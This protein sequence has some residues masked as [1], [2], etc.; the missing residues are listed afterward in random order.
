LRLLAVAKRN[1]QKASDNR[2][3][4]EKDLTF[5]GFV[6]IADPPRKEIKDVLSVTRKAGIATIMVTGDNPVTARAIASQIGLIQDGE[7]VV[8]GTELGKMSDDELL[9]KIDAIRIFARTTP[10]DKLRIVRI[11]QK[12]GEI[13]T[14]TG[15]GV[16]DALA[17]KQAHTGVAMGITG[18][19]VSKEVADMVIM[20]DNFASIISAVREGR[21]IFDNMVTSVRYLVSSNI[22]EILLIF[23]AM[24]GSTL[25]PSPIPTPLLPV[26]ILWINLVTDGLPALSLAF[27]RE[28]EK[29][30]N[31]RTHTNAILE[32]KH[33]FQMVAAGVVIGAVSLGVFLYMLQ[34]VG[35]HQARTITFNTIVALQL[36]LVFFIR[37]KQPF[38]TNKILL[39]SILVSVLLQLMIFFVPPFP[40]VFHHE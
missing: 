29:T 39:A 23:G 3:T 2:D 18:T 13:V 5:L 10:E 28:S 6:G 35:V 27:D 40:T 22:S 31:K 8:T 1:I 32:K 11:L 20:D 38:F 19:D 12:K 4:M 21:I 34:V 9:Q 33:V 16:N 25:T 24:V 15:D 37:D 26:H 14:A 36:G 7:L 30:M 17:I